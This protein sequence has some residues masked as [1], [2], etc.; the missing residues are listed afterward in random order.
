MFTANGAAEST[1]PLSRSVDSLLQ[2]RADPTENPIQFAGDFEVPYSQDDPPGILEGSV[3]RSI[4]LD[5]PSDLLIPIFPGAPGLVTGGVAVPEGAVDEDRNAKGRPCQIRLARRAPIVAP[6][7]R[8][9]AA[10]SARR[11]CSSGG[12]SVLRTAAMIRRRCS[13]VRVSVTR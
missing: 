8:T 3:V 2:G 5:V 6:Q 4:A 1:L 10:K 13:G 11:S 9:P 12:V 7:P